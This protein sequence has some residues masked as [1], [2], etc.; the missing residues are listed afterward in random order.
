M[1]TPTILVCLIAFICLSCRERQLPDEKQDTTIV[2]KREV[3]IDTVTT[4][5][6]QPDTALVFKTPTGKYYRITYELVDSG[7]TAARLDCTKDDFFGDHRKAAKTSIATGT[8]SSYTVLTNFLKTL[9]ADSVMEKH[10]LIKP[11][12]TN[13][14]VSDEK[15]NVK[16]TRVFMY[17][18]KRED[19][20][21]Y[22]II[23]GDGKGN[24][25]NVECS[26]LPPVGTTYYSRLSK[27]RK[28]VK[29]FFGPV[30]MSAYRKFQPAMEVEVT[31]SLF[32]DIDHDAGAVGPVGL[33][34]KTA[35]EVHPVTNI[36]FK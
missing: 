29:D 34:P 10:P 14:R 12:S 15:R 24:F 28:Q 3:A 19:D 8:F 4:L 7:I 22:H 32:F 9:K 36:V 18:I 17:A 11:A 2:R 1:H 27:A 13:N 16:L 21:D 6:D 33:R 20:N 25:L 23:I 26:G 35:W 31:G 30:C 5:T